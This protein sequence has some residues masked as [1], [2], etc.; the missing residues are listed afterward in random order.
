MRTAPEF[1]LGYF[2]F[3]SH[4]FLPVRECPISSPLINRVMAQLLELGGLDCPAAVEEIELFADAADERLL[5]WAF[6]GREAEQRDL[7]RWA[8]ALRARLPEISGVTFFSSRRRIEEDE[9][10]S[11]RKSLAQSGAN[12][13]RY[14]TKEPRISG[15]RGSLLPGEP[16]SDGR[17]GFG[18]HRQRARGRRTRPLC[19]SGVVFGGFG[20]KV[21]ITFLL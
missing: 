3:G 2:R 11:T 12:G 1:A 6:C 5:A 17:T 13:I 14:R 21:F 4:E 10:P 18:R 7:L 8:E 16:L 19:R 20:A 9:M 15:Q